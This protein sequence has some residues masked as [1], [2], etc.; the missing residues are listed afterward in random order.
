MLMLMFSSKKTENYRF[1]LKKSC[2]S[3]FFFCFDQVFL[4]VLEKGH[5]LVYPMVL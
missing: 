4:P 5:T 2:I 1:F 3:H